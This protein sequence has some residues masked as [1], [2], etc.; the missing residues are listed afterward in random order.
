MRY[1]HVW[2]RLFFYLPKLFDILNESAILVPFL[3][4]KKMANILLDDHESIYENLVK[5]VTEHVSWL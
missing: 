3:R 2:D 4:Y 1:E 5:S